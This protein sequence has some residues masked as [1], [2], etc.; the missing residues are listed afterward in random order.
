MD[1]ACIH[2]LDGNLLETNLPYKSQYGW[3]Q[4][5][6]KSLNIRDLL[7]EHLKPEFDRYLERII[8]KGS[9]GYLEGLTKNGSAVILE[10]RNTLIYDADG[11]PKAVQGAASDVTEKLRAERALRKARKS[12]A[13]LSSMRRP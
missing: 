11:Q 9:D 5:D 7:P 10:Y 2:D 12:I 8:R 3:G 4:Q 6:I 1:L 13:S